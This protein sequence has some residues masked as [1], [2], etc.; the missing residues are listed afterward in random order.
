MGAL[1]SR[2]LKIGNIILGR[3]EMN[4]QLYKLGN[5]LSSI[6]SVIFFDCSKTFQPSDQRRIML[7]FS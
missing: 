3:Y 6:K 2:K 1:K 5:Y 4:K 7:F